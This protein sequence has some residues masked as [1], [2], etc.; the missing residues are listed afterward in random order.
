MNLGR[1]MT[2]SIQTYLKDFN[3]LFNH[4]LDRVI[5]FVLKDRTTV[6]ATAFSLFN[7]GIASILFVII[8]TKNAPLGDGSQ[9]TAGDCGGGCG[10]RRGGDGEDGRV[11][12]KRCTNSGSAM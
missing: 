5:I 10:G 3:Y 7:L 8:V 4:D 11:K 9:T 12:V 2:A 6:K 1:T